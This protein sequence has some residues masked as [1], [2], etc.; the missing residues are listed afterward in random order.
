MISL[1]GRTALITGANQGLGKAIAAAYM[2]A[3]ASVFLC[4]RNGVLLEQVAK[5]LADNRRLAEELGITGTPAFVIGDEL[6]PGAIDATQ[7]AL[8]VG[9]ARKQNK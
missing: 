7:M 9:A 1:N 3:G 4:A 8:L 6:V 5:E 2:H